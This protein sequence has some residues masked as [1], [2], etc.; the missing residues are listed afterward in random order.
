M[1]RP[2]AR[3]RTIQSLRI[4]LVASGVATA[5][6]LLLL[7]CAALF[8][9]LFVRLGSGAQIDAEI[10]RVADRLLFLHENFW[11][12]ALVSLLAPCLS[13][14]LL[15]N[16]MTQPLVRFRRAFE[17]VASGRVPEAVCLRDRD[18]LNTEAA[19][20][21]HMLECL[22]SRAERLGRLRA[23]LADSVAELEEL[24]ADERTE[25][26]RQRLKELDEQLGWL[27]TAH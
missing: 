2:D 3:I 8:V 23:E 22:R 10:L 18:Y 21:N 6:A 12:V 7:L 25:Q 27:V 9:P 1:A 13:S 24:G 5:A 26:L 17:E 4:H 14:Y 16:R 11:P 15:Y 20:L 19:A